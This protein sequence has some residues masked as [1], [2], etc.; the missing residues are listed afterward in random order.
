MPPEAKYSCFDSVLIVDDSAVQRSLGAALCRQCGI[1]SVHEA[2]NGKEAL[3]VLESLPRPPALLIIDLE[4]PTMDGLELLGRLREQR[5]RAPIIVASSRERALIESVRDLGSALGLVILGTLSKPLTEATLRDLLRQDPNPSSEVTST[6]LVDPVDAEELR[7]GIE[8]GEI[9]VHY[10]PQVEVETGYVRGLEALARWQHPAQGLIGPD[11]FIPVAEQH[12]LIHRL[13]LQIMDQA[14]SQAAEWHKEGLDLSIAINLSPT[15]LDDADLVEEVSSQQA[16]HGIPAHQVILEVT[17]TALPDELP[18]ALSVLTRLRLRGFGLSLD[19]YGAGFSSMRRLA[20]TPFTEL[21][22]D[23][24]FVHGADE[25]ENLKTIL[26]SALELA[27]NLQ[28]T[29]V[30]EG[31]ESL[32]DW[33]L[34]RERGCTFAQGWLFAKAMP[35]RKF[36]PWL[37]RHLARRSELLLGPDDTIPIENLAAPRDSRD[38]KAADAGTRSRTRRAR[39]PRR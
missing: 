15:L 21:K 16:R 17:E 23:R 28:M 32:Q 20:R 24:A 8:R 14:L 25:R 1:G 22:I 26:C 2:T 18:T 13:T 36:G 9:V 6:R 12:G 11:R 19:D 27:R 35:A 4:M 34:L 30:A 39:S 33:S 31:V 3:A 7:L 37:K 10:Q 38:N 5:L 29:T